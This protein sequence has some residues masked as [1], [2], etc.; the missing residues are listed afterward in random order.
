MPYISYTYASGGPPRRAAVKE[1]TENLES[2]LDQATSRNWLKYD[3]GNCGINASDDYGSSTTE[4]RRFTKDVLDELDSTQGLITDENVMIA[5]NK[6]AWGYGGSVSHTT[7]KGTSCYGATVYAGW[8]ANDWET[9]AFTW[10]ECAHAYVAGSEASDHEKGTYSLYNGQ[11]YD[12]T[13]L[14]TSYLYNSDGQCDTRFEGS[15]RPL[16]SSFC[17]GESN[18]QY[19]FRYPY[20]PETGHDY[21][22]YS[23]CTI[24]AIEDWL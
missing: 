17:N 5:H 23:S 22:K 18:N 15:A 16:P 19:V 4:E 24:D 3:F 10:H 14:C 21:S 13:P 9:R 1:E 8:G 6:W 11:M 12:I 2:Y 20:H 7:D